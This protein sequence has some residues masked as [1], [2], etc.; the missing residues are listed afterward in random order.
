M[1]DHSETCDVMKA[2]RAWQDMVARQE[3]HSDGNMLDFGDSQTNIGWTEHQ[4][5]IIPIIEQMADDI[6]DCNTPAEA[7]LLIKNALYQMSLITY[8]MGRQRE[9]AQV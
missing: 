8:I 7:Y 9:G 1:K 4:T 2:Y 5:C 3:E 6:M